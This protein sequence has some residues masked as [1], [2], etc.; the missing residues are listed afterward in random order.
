[1]M[2]LRRIVFFVG[3]AVSLLPA[4]TVIAA[5]ADFTCQVYGGSFVLDDNDFKALELRGLAKEKFA[6]LEAASV[7]RE[8]AC[9]TRMLWRL[10]RDG[11]A[12]QC[13]LVV[14]YKHYAIAYFHSS[15]LA[16]VTEL[17]DNPRFGANWPTCR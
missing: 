3:L 5:G 4:S 13:D 2:K 12:D 15:E 1:M 7:R 14:H 9:E 8:S 11:K 17:F 10:I 6:A 16:K